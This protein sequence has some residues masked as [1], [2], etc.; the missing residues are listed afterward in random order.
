MLLLP[1]GASPHQKTS[2][3]L[4]AFVNLGA[5]SGFCAADHTDISEMVDDTED[6]L[7][8]KIL[9]DASHVLSQLL[10]EHRIELTYSL[11]T[12]RHDRTGCYH[13]PLGSLIT[14]LLHGSFLR[15][16]ISI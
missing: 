4:L 7:F 16:V 3:V 9:N 15:I 14:I 12:R 6:K 8:H 11:R 10:P 1:G 13:K 5:L 2:T